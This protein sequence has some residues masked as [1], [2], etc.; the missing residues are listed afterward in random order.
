MF[1]RFNYIFDSDTA[2][3]KDENYIEIGE[4][5]YS[6]FQKISELCL[7]K[8]ILDNGHIDATA[9]KEHWFGTIDADVFISHSHIDL[10]E[11]K[12]FAGWLYK[13]FGLKSFIDSC[14]WGYCDELLREIDN[15]FCKR[16]DEDVYDYN[17]RNCS[18]SHVHTMLATALTEMM[19]IT[20]CLIFF[21]TPQSIDLKTEIAEANSKSKANTHSPWIYHELSISGMLKVKMPERYR[22]MISNESLQENHINFI[23]DNSM[24]FD[25]DVSEKLAKMITIDNDTLK[26][27]GRYNINSKVKGAKAL[28]ELYKV[29]KRKI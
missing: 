25:Y 10:D 22:K 23:K 20:E 27:W 3:F 4:K 9:L 15:K 11:V 28:D 6:D 17:S 29:C 8:F 7:K 1:K 13:K 21:N 16:H 5:I 18:T 2:P 14:A 24:S 19:D 26:N 12:S